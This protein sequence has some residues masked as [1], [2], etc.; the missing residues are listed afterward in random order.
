MRAELIIA[1][2]SLP[3]IGYAV[4]LI[5]HGFRDDRTDEQ[6]AKEQATGF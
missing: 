5:S 3:L 4:Y 2:L 1:A 6:A